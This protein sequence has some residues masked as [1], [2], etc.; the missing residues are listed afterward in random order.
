MSAE[1]GGTAPVGAP[2]PPPL[3]YAALR[4][5]AQQRPA[6]AAAGG[7]GGSLG[8]LTAAPRDEWAKAR[9]SLWRA[10]ASNRASLEV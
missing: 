5:L 6:A 10:S 1:G 4:R 7:G 2:L 8:A 9:E 3:L